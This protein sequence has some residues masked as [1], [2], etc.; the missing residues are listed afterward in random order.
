MT[1]GAAIENP[2]HASRSRHQAPETLASGARPGSLPIQ[3]TPGSGSYYLCASLRA[4]G[5][6]AEVHYRA[7]WLLV[8]TFYQ[9]A[10]RW[11]TRWFP[12]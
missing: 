9:V 5:V 3:L 8:K 10:G 12:E 4:A 2:E 7:T 11:S 1:R 6:L